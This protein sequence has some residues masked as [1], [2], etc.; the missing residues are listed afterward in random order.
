MCLQCLVDKGVNR[1]IYN[2]ICEDIVL[3]YGMQ[4]IISM[5]NL[6]NLGLFYEQGAYNNPFNFNEIKKELRLISE[7]KINH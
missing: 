1:K 4:H 6:A 2:R 7:D 5:T 3:T